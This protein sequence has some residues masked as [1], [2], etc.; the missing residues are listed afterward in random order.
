[1]AADN[2][3][4]NEAITTVATPA[5]PDTHKMTPEERL[6]FYTK[7]RKRMGTSALSV[8]PPKGFTAYWARK[9]D[10]KEMSRLDILGFSIV[11]DDPKNPKWQA[12]GRK[13]DGTYQLGDVILMQIPTDEYQFFLA[14]NDVRA[15]QLVEGARS[16]VQSEAEKAGVPTF[17]VHKGEK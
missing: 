6:A 17:E 7:M 3:Q 11:H 4:R 16:T 8:I 15:K 9:D 1:M 13:Q 12:N 2:V 10:A 14:E 5:T